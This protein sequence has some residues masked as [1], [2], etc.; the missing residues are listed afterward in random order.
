MCAKYESAQLGRT[1]SAAARDLLG[2]G[3]EARSHRESE[4]HLL[5][6]THTA[7]LPPKACRGAILLARRLPGTA[8]G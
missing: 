8:V 7:L 2:E 1:G 5:H 3:S 4:T 6:G